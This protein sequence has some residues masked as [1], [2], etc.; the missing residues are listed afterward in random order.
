MVRIDPVLGK[1]SIVVT[2]GILLKGKELDLD[3]SFF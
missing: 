1:D 2:I 3:I